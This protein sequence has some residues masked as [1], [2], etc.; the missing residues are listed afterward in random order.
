MPALIAAAPAQARRVHRFHLMPQHADPIRSVA[1]RSRGP[2]ARTSGLAAN[3]GC[4]E[5]TGDESPLLSNAPQIKVVYAYPA[6]GSDQL[7][8]G[9][10][11]SNVIEADAAAVDAKVEAT[12]AGTKRIRFDVGGVGCASAASDELDIQTVALAHPAAWYEANDQ[13]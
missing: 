12:S 7:V 4:L 2:L 1:K 11:Y 3:W 8:T 13:T 10:T 5:Q 6:D 9:N